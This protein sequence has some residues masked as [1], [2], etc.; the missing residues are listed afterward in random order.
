MKQNPA[1]NLADTAYT[2]SLG[3]AQFLKRRIIAWRQ[4]ETIDRAFNNAYDATAPSQ[5]R[6]VV[7]LFPG[8]G[9]QYPNMGLGLYRGERVFREELDRCFEILTPLL[10]ENPRNII[11]PEDVNITQATARLNQ[12]EFAQPLLFSIE[13]ATARLLQSCGIHISAMLGHSLGE[14]TAACLAGVFSPE[15]GLFLTATRGKLMGEIPPGGNTSVFATENVIRPHLNGG[16][17]ISTYAPG[18]H[19]VSGGLEAL[20]AFETEMGEQEIEFRRLNVPNAAHCELTRLIQEPYKAKIKHIQFR[21][22]QIPLLS[23]LTGDWMSDAEA[24]DPARWSQH[25]CEPVQLTK[26]LGKLLEKQSAAFIEAGPG[27]GLSGFGQQHPEY[28]ENH[29]FE[30]TIRSAAQREKAPEIDE[31]Y[32]MSQTLGKL[33]ARGV[34]V[35][36]EQYYRG[37]K[38]G[39]VPLP[40]YPFQRKSFRIAPPVPSLQRRPT[41]RAQTAPTALRTPLWKET[42]SPESGPP[43]NGIPIF[44][45]SSKGESAALLAECKRAGREFIQVKDGKNFKKLERNIFEINFARSEDYAKLIGELKSNPIKL[46]YTRSLAPLSTSE[47][48]YLSE[49]LFITRA[50]ERQ[51]RRASLQIFS[52]GALELSGAEVLKEEGAMIA[53]ALEYLN[54]Q[55]GI[56]NCVLVDFSGED[57][58]LNSRTTNQILNEVNHISDESSVAYR[59]NRRWARS[60]APSQHKQ[61]ALSEKDGVCLILGD[62]TKVRHITKTLKPI[63]KSPPLP[64]LE[65]SDPT[66]LKQINPDPEREVER[67]ARIEREIKNEQNIIPLN[68]IPG[69]MQNLDDICANLV[70]EYF[71]RNL[72]VSPGAAYIRREFKRQLRLLDKFDKYLDFFLR[73][74]REDGFIKLEG[75]TIEFLKNPREGQNHFTLKSRTLQK[76]PEFENVIDF[77]EIC[78]RSYDESLSGLKETAEVLRPEG[79]DSF[80]LHKLEEIYNHDSGKIYLAMA[81]DVIA[82]LVRRADGRK[83]RILEF[84]AGSGG[85]T[86][87]MLETLKAANVD[88]HFT[89]I[90]RLFVTEAAEEAQRRGYT[91]MRFSRF[92]ITADPATQEVDLAGYDLIVGYNVAQVG[93]DLRQNLKNLSELLKPGGLMLQVQLFRVERWHHIIFGL[94]PGWWDYAD[95]LRKDSLIIDHQQW[96]EIIRGGDFDR[97]RIFPVS[98]IERKQLDH[99]LVLARKSETDEGLRSVNLAD[100][101]E[102]SYT[103][104]EIQKSGEAVTGVIYAPGSSQTW[105]APATLEERLQSHSRKLQNLKKIFETHP[106]EFF[107]LLNEAISESMTTT[108]SG[109]SD[110]I[111]DFAR[112][113][114]SD[115]FVSLENRNDGAR[116]ISARLKQETGKISAELLS[117]L[118]SNPGPLAV[119]SGEQPTPTPRPEQTTRIKQKEAG[120]PSESLE[121]K[122]NKLWQRSL[123]IQKIGR[124]DDFFALG[125]DSLTA[126][127]LLARLRES[128]GYPVKMG[129]FIENPTIAHMTKLLREEAGQSTPRTDGGKN[130]L[131]CLIP[132]QTNG[133]QTPLFCVHPVGGSPL[134]YMNLSR[135]LGTEQPLYGFQSP[136]LL[137]D[138]KTPTS[139]E[140]MAA[141]YIGEMQTL[142]PEGPYQLGGWSGGGVIAYEMARQL[143]RQNQRVDLL[144]M[145]DAGLENVDG[146][147]KGNSILGVASALKDATQHFFTTRPP[148]SWDELTMFGQWL[149]INLPDSVDSFLKKD[150]ISMLGYGRDLALEIPRLIPV[151]K[152]NFMAILNY[153]PGPYQGQVIV[154]RA[155]QDEPG[156]DDPAVK[157]FQTL[158]RGGLVI[159]RVPGNHMTLLDKNNSK[160]LA[161]SLSEF[162]TGPT[163]R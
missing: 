31:S 21:P 77:L 122:V 41:P 33:W 34:S 126:V 68:S 97:V 25:L 162:L 57:A 154:F 69:L 63:L 28:T 38:R 18:L 50:L 39:R 104:S 116:W 54:V 35:N 112:V 141:L 100:T 82:D 157:S 84:G 14:Y 40:T 30:S 91:S 102:F 52:Y 94:Q 147:Q 1:R 5:E 159:R 130:D 44:F 133:N 161:Q 74:A 24:T 151:Y 83:I 15:D 11:F 115:A 114:L 72:D 20:R 79:D 131:R 71:Q 17:S 27:R 42:Q 150:F 49:L 138:F 9:V 46:I 65:Q 47:T 70:Y 56:T 107:L 62:A 43:D 95:D 4:G 26:G 111:A 90:G 73:I 10:G 113:G 81:R 120:A 86:W 16:L 98:E 153:I 61:Q 110:V 87:P 85:F 134:C 101:R 89:D 29:I 58:V 108:D 129:D 146:G 99:G 137:D 109:A 2:L 51:N 117:E 76:H 128:L 148:T 106:P 7:L 123:G 88:Y 149:G 60:L 22:P 132:I 119:V 8:Q 118:Y 6:P 127:H 93:R 67:Y 23:N 163:T 37:E 45:T 78:A 140:E 158:A 125:G 80:A 152:T 55:P 3:R 32:I 156:Q 142:Q 124:E 48:G 75:E 92:D 139:I 64:L 145:F 103:L 96:E 59:G 19:V 160:F 36:W 136:G 121:T 53:G 66:L 155:I 105:T 135:H 13:Y 12:V 144:A 143:N